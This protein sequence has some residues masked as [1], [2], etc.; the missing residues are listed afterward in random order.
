MHDTISKEYYMKK[1]LTAVFCL[2]AL[3]VYLPAAEPD[4]QAML[5]E[6]D[7]LG[8]FEGKDFSCIYTIVAEKPGED[9]DVTQARMFRRDTT[10]QFV[11]LIMKPDAKRG[12]GYLQADENVWFYDPES[13]KFEKS[14][15]REN[16]QESDAQNSDIKTNTLSV[17]YTVVQSRE[18]KLGDFSVYIL[19]LAAKHQDVSYD[20]IKVW[21][22]KDKTIILKEEDYSVNNRLM[23]TLLF[24]NYIT[25]DGKYTPSKV[26]IID[27]LNTGEKTQ[28]TMKDA[29]VSPIPDYVFTKSYIEKVSN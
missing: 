4:F 12:Q 25:V 6:I 21:I 20:K 13:R 26:L 15:I 8:N 28:L 17:D 11:L 29:S 7:D 18:G 24:P 27:E 22:R 5:K 3:S 9:V 16:I 1:F 10:D 19:D 23:R 2:S 14:T